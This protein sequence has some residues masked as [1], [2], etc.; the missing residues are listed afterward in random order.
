M[1]APSSVMLQRPIERDHAGAPMTMSEL[2]TR[3][4][5]LAIFIRLDGNRTQAQLFCSRR[6]STQESAIVP[7]PA[8]ATDSGNLQVRNHL[9]SP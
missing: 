4:P 5:R 7:Q 6:V 8:R 3:G 9:S 2:H 1:I